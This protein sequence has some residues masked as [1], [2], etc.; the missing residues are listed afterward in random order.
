MEFKIQ[1]CVHPLIINSVGIKF[2][3]NRSTAL[4]LGYLCTCETPELAQAMANNLNAAYKRVT[5]EDWAK[6]FIEVHA[7]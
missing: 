2:S 5:A 7:K 1:Y 4:Y 6:Q 3:N